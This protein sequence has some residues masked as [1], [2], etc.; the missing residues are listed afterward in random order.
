M[1]L[2]KCSTAAHDRTDIDHARRI[3]GG[4]RPDQDRQQ[5]LGQVK[6]ARHV[7]IHHLFPGCV[8]ELAKRRAPGDPGIVHQDVQGVGAVRDLLDQRGDPL[9]GTDIAC[10][11]FDAAGTA[12]GVQL[13]CHGHAGIPL[14]AGD[15]HARARHHQPC[16]GHAPDSGRASG[17]KRHLARQ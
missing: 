12:H 8:R 6:Q 3:V 1:I 13:L 14:A 10:E 4:A 17:D 2:V 16:G 11:P 9:F 7:H 15:Q 5:R